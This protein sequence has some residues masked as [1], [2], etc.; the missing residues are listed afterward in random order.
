MVPAFLRPS[1]QTTR[2]HVP[3][4][5]AWSRMARDQRR[6]WGRGR[7]SSRRALQEQS[8]AGGPQG[9]SGAW[10]KDS[11]HTWQVGPELDDG[12]CWASPRRTIRDNR[13]FT[14]SS[15]GP[16]PP[17]R[18]LKQVGCVVDIKRVV[19]EVTDSTLWSDVLRVA[20][21]SNVVS[22]GPFSSAYGNM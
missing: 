4:H 20:G 19:T 11:L 1:N 16:A 17:I 21:L 13:P 14:P 15:S 3:L 9:G 2:T 8:A 7:P 5:Q 18:E 12:L 6:S 10:M 22:I